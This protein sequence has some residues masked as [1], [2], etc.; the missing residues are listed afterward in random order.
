MEN[1]AG[2]FADA[3]GRHKP[4]RKGT[5]SCIE[6]RRRKIRC[7][8]PSEAENCDPCAARGTRCTAQTHSQPRVTATK[9]NKTL[10]EKIREL[11]A[12]INNILNRTDDGGIASALPDNQRHIDM[13]QILRDLQLELQPMGDPLPPSSEAG[14]ASVDAITASTGKAPIMSLFDNAILCRDDYD[15]IN[16]GEASICPDQLSLHI[17]K[18]KAFADERNKRILH[19]LQTLMPGEAAV[20]AII[21][22][23]T[24]SASVCQL[25]SN[26][27]EIPGL[28]GQPINESQVVILSSH[29]VNSIRS[30]NVEIAVKAILCFAICIQQLPSDF[31]LLS[32][33]TEPVSLRVLQDCCMQSVEALMTPDDGIIGTINGLEC[34]LTQIRYYLNAGFPRKAWV[35]L[36]RAVTF[37]QLIG[38][39][40]RDTPQKPI[41]VRK[42]A[43][44]SHLWHVDKSLSL[45]LGLP[46]IIKRF[47]YRVDLESDAMPAT[48][49]LGFNL[50]NLAERII[51][52]NQNP[53]N[54]SYD[55]TM[56]MEWDLHQYRSSMPP[57]FWD[58]DYATE[59]RVNMIQEAVMLRFW[60]NNL[61]LLLHLPFVL[62]CF[63]DNRV[64][65]FSPQAALDSARQ[66]IN[67]YFI[68]RDERRPVLWTCNITDFQA[69]TAGTVIVLC[70]M[71]NLK[72]YDMAQRECDWIQIQRLI[73][74]MEQVARNMPD[75][76]ATQGLQVLRTLTQIQRGDGG[77]GE[78]FKAVIPYFGKLSIRCR[79]N[80]PFRALSLTEAT[81]AN[82]VG[83][84]QDI[85]L[86]TYFQRDHFQ[87]WPIDSPGWLSSVDVGLQDDWTWD[88]NN[89]E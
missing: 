44:W 28:D 46:D 53:D 74:V 10:R 82:T 7:F 21:R 68:M 60:H 85:E 61:R 43:I 11:E 88:F 87:H 75:G 66:M 69:F 23:S 81:S 30:T 78:S 17:L 58:T 1:P 57:Q 50:A 9:K 51:A 24:S 80:I 31:V 79:E 54:M 89:E 49:K 55:D 38:G 20:A 72:E 22:A 42:K 33:A 36:H 41:C 32:H 56:Q 63:S 39:T 70:S 64:Y 37:A 73:H 2:N 40:F 16:E 3:T 18:T 76:V 27:P 13:A 34:M 83:I 19:N 84:G 15:D 35:I 77:Q 29:I 71:S 86:D 67:C 5:R 12:T 4:V 47:P 62:R 26:F 8:W 59:P 52:R 6:C 45:V 14:D 65:T 25:R 48:A